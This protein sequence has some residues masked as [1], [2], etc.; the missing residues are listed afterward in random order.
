MFYQAQVDRHFLTNAAHGLIRVKGGYPVLRFVLADESGTDVSGLDKRRA[1]T[2]SVSSFRI[3][4]DRDRSS[5]PA[6]ASILSII[7]RGIW[8][9][10]TGLSASDLGFFLLVL[11]VFIA[12]QE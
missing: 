9:L 8:M 6:M 2:A 3:S 4:H 10:T 12:S 5:F 11:G 7:S 1:A